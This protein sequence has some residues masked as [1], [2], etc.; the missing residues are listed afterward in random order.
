[1]SK[2]RKD[3]KEIIKAFTENAAAG[4]GALSFTAADSIVLM[5]VVS[6]KDER[7]ISLCLDY[8]LK[9]EYIKNFTVYEDYYEANLTSKGVDFA[10]SE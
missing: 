2:I 10:E 6:V 5:D 7:Y 9:S 8:L 3:S 1:M 4:S